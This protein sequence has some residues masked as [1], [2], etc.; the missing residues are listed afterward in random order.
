MTDNRSRIISANDSH[1]LMTQF[2][3]AARN[4][5]IAMCRFD[6]DHAAQLY[7][8]EAMHCALVG[9]EQVR[10]LLASQKFRLRPDDDKE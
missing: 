10:K 4:I 6:D 8:D 5:H 3:D 7:M 1:V 2:L 9:A